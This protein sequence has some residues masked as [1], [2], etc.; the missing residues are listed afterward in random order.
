[1]TELYFSNSCTVAILIYI[2]CMFLQFGEAILLNKTWNKLAV[3]SRDKGIKKCRE[4]IAITLLKHSGTIMLYIH[5]FIDCTDDVCRVC[6][7]TDDTNGKTWVTSYIA[8]L[9]AAYICLYICTA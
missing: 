5:V 3:L 7:Q 2:T 1:M 4:E 6:G 8:I 9:T